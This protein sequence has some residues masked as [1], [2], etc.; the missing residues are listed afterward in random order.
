VDVNQVAGKIDFMVG[1]MGSGTQMEA[2]FTDHIQQAYDANIPML[3]LFRTDPELYYDIGLNLAR[4]PQGLNDPQM[5]VIN[6]QIM[7]GNSQRVLHGIILDITKYMNSD[8]RTMAT[9]N[10]VKHVAMHMVKQIWDQYKLP[11]WLFVTMR[12][13]KAYEG[14]E[15]LPT[16]LYG[17]EEICSWKSAFGAAA[18]DPQPASWSD[19][20]VPPDSY[21]M[22]YVYAERV[23]FFQH[24]MTK[25]RFPGITDGSGQPVSVPLWMF[26]GSKSSMRNALNY[27]IPYVIPTNPPPS[28]PPGDTPTDP[29]VASSDL[30]LQVTRIANALER[31]ADHMES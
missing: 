25:F 14:S 28:D 26:N 7:S 16:Y 24:A 3:G 11:I 4:F 29:P 18:G 15:V 13:V 31:I 20:P 12:L 9:D 8:G 19:F 30:L 5:K 10:W 22:E 1:Y 27:T 23:A 2:R 17:Q 6:R 21:K